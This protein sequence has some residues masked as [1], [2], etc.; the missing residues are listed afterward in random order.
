MKNLFYCEIAN[1]MYCR[2][3]VIGLLGIFERVDFVKYFKISNG[4]SLLLSTF[5]VRSFRRATKQERF[6]FHMGI[7]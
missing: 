7:E 5:D 1:T 2:N 6:L 3:N 4:H